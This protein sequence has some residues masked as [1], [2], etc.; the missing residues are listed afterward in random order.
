M[1]Y[2]G[3]QIQ[4][5]VWHFVFFTSPSTF[6]STY[7][8]DSS[9]SGQRRTL[10]RFYNGLHERSHSASP[11]R[12]PPMLETLFCK[13]GISENQRISTEKRTL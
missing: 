12:V 9:C 7:F 11:R 1:N 8:I 3:W 10:G 4:E 2:F 5:R 13:S 6:W